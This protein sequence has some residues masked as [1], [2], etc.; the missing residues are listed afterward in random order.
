MFIA[1]NIMK[2]NKNLQ[3]LSRDHHHGLLFGWKIRKGLTTLADPD[4]II[5]Y[6]EYF[7]KSALFP[8]FEEEEKQVLIYL[9]DND[10]FKQR[11][12]EEH[13]RIRKLTG[14]II[15]A[16]SASSSQLLEVARLLDEHIRFEER[17]LFP[18][19]EK[20]LTT[21]QL[22]E[23]GSVIEASHTPF[24]EKFKNEFWNTGVRQ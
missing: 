9:A 18:Y 12:L 11:T 10:S 21:D 24:V 4:L 16:I 8:H 3:A 2:R 15:K 7:S 19:L 5:Q 13:E 14:R 17:E 23:M 6:V 22:N 1:L 20:V